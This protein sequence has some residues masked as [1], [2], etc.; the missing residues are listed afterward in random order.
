M[1]RA[2]D[3]GATD[4]LNKPVNFMELAPRIRNA[5]TIKRYH[6]Q[7]QRHADELQRQ[8]ELKTASLQESHA[9][10]QRT[11]LVL[12]RAC[13]AA[14]AATRVKSGFLANI[15]HEIRTP[16]TAIIGFSEELIVDAGTFPP[17][18]LEVLQIILRNGR[19]LLQIVDDVLDVS[20]IDRGR[21]PIRPAECSPRTILAEVVQLLRPSAFRKELELTVEVARSVPDTILT[22]PK[23]L[24]QILLNLV[25]NAVQYTDRGSVHVDLR[26]IGE[27]ARDPRLQFT[28]AD[29]GKGIDPQLLSEIFKPFTRVRANEDDCG[30]GTGLGLTICKHLVKELGGDIVVS[31]RPGVGSTFRFTVAACPPHHFRP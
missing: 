3:L 7:L 29:S 27:P 16:L 14:E 25:N 31:S 30:G 28:V 8:V 13:E 12:R 15:S 17:E 23:R 26:A 21:L 20:Q 10:L 6:D 22:D 9:E 19:Q 4:F 11:N 18:A 2:F 1:V 24:R 5:L